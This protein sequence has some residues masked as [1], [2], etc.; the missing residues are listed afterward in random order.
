MGIFTRFFV[1]FQLASIGQEGK[2][3][4]LAGVLLLSVCEFIE[5]GRGFLVHL[6]VE[7]ESVDTRLS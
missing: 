4:R 6:R 7:V 5:C 3:H 1:I 2:H